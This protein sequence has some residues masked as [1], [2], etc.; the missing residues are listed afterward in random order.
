MKPSIF[1]REYE[2]K[3]KRRK[4]MIK[5]FILIAAVVAAGGFLILNIKPDTK[6]VSQLK[7]EFNIKKLFSSSNQVNQKKNTDAKVQKEK[8]K[9]ASNV[10]KPVTEQPKT[11]EETGYNISMSNGQTVK[12]VYDTIDNVKKFKYVTPVGAVTDFN[13]SPSGTNIVLYDAKMQSMYYIDI[14]GNNQEVT[15][16]KYISGSGTVFSKDDYINSH[17]SYIW[18]A[19]PKFI[20][21]DT[22]VYVSQ[23]PWFGSKT[24]KYLWKYNIKT[25][26]HKQIHGVEG[27][28]IKINAITA[29]GMEVVVDNKSIYIGSDGNIVE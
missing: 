1:S 11:T 18:C 21:E 29:K 26:E 9:P 23:M 2:R 14:N 22:I 3:M 8:D 19:S 25:K 5:V 27:D 20:S 7:N 13:I 12:V 17:P 15:N 4:K 24:T 10:K 6:K 28:D 16:S